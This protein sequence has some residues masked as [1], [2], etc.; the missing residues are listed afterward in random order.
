MNP[1]IL[2][3]HNHRA[4]FVQTDLAVLREKY[5]AREWYQQS[6]TVNV[7]A[8]ARAA[9]QSDLIFGWFASW[10]TFFPLLLA[11]AA[12][13]PSLLIVG[14]YDTAK[15]PD[16]GYGSQRGGIKQWIA[17][18]TM[19]LAT[20][21]ITFSEFSRGEA[22]RNARISRD[23]IVVIYLGVENCRHTPGLKESIVVTTCNVERSTL[24]RK[25]IEPFVRA[26]P[27]TPNID[28]VVIGAWRDNT[29]HY[30]R[31]IAAPNVRFTG[32]LN[33]QELRDYLS[34]AR[35]YVQ[36]SRHEGFGLAVAEAML[37]ECVPVVTRAGALPEVVGETG[38]YIDSPDPGAVA[39]GI[40]RALALDEGWGKR[41]RERAEREFSIA[42][43]REQLYGLVDR[44]MNGHR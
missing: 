40:K 29:I 39:D 31:S 38:V 4:K 16:I 23:K 21:L 35:V 42:R 6:R 24:I 26:A 33:E 20:R 12:K 2:F 3:V 27:F 25:G 41:A 22:I 18:V 14:G 37:N 13:K 10:H 5:N 17:R 32:W 8:L 15:M 1:H 43:R 19:R 44:M 34:R 30:L 28:F 9:T 7:P 11:R 36:A